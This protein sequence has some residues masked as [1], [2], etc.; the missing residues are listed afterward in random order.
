M[1]TAVNDPDLAPPLHIGPAETI[2]FPHR[3]QGLTPMSTPN[4]VFETLS[5]ETLATA[6][7]GVASSNDSQLRHQ[8]SPLIHSLKDL[9]TS[10]QANAQNQNNTMMMGMMAAMMARRNG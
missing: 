8:L 6:T 7:G 10:S 2:H 9:N 4:N 3:F 5:T 1:A